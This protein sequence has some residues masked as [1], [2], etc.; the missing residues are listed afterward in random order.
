[1]PLTK[2]HA[3]RT[4][5]YG[6]VQMPEPQYLVVGQILTRGHAAA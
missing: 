1:M 5:D 4:L 3:P 2:T 6:Y